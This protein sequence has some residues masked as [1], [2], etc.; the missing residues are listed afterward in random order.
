MKFQ[1]FDQ[2]HKS[3]IAQWL[4]ISHLVD[5]V[6]TVAHYLAISCGLQFMAAAVY[7]TARI[8]NRNFLLK[9]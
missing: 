9:V 5:V 1:D 8:L 4:C 6:T 2:N 3:L 7:P